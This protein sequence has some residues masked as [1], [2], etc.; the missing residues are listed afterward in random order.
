MIKIDVYKSN[1]I[2]VKK[3]MCVYYSIINAHFG[4]MCF[5]TQE[6]SASHNKETLSKLKD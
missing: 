3:L 1:K 2:C 5:D 6:K 4:D